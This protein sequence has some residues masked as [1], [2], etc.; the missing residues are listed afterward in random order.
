M[1]NRN[2]PSSVWIRALSTFPEVDLCRKSS[3]SYNAETK[4]NTGVVTPSTEHWHTKRDG[5]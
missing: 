5:P 1:S 4:L 3:L 2:V